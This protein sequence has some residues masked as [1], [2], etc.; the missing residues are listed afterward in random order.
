M[1]RLHRQQFLQLLGFGGLGYV[2]SR[3]IQQLSPYDA[4]QLDKSIVREFVAAGHSNMDRVK[5]LLEA[6][7]SL[8]NAAHDWKMG[9]FETCLGAATHVGFK[10]LAQFLIEQG[11]QTN[12]FTATMFGKIEVV[13]P[14]L[15]AFPETIH[16]KGPHGLSLLYHA[17]IG[18]EEAREVKEYLESLGAK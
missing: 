7:P 4:P 3:L 13:K 17:T 15:T 1:K 18:G 8:L 11:A 12:I 5:T 16:A 6:H 9:D 2:S 10:E 14:M